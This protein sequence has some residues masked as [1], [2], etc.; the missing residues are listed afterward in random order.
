VL[1][2]IGKF[3]KKQAEI[4]KVSCNERR[5]VH[6]YEMQKLPEIRQD[7]MVQHLEAMV[8]PLLT[9]RGSLFWIAFLRFSLL[10]HISVLCHQKTKIYALESKIEKQHN[11]FRTSVLKSVVEPL[12]AFYVSR[13]ASV[14]SSLSIWMLI[15]GFC[16]ELTLTHLWQTC[17]GEAY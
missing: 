2:R 3:S 1:L 5:K 9:S 12:F 17:S 16:G 8:T 14:F 11:F 13:S 10:T 4:L 7:Q 15:G 6:A